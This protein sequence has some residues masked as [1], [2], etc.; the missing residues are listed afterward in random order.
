MY[1]YERANKQADE[2]I[3]SEQSRAT[4]SARTRMHTYTNTFLNKQMR[5]EST[6]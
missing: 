6:P 5:A 1:T 3:H 2:Q 4:T